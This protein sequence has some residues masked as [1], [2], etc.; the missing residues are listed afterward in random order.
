[1][2]GERLPVQDWMRA[3]ATRTV[4]TA[5]E[6]AGGPGA[7][8]FV[9]GC[10]R[11]AVIGRPIDDID[12]ATTL[13]P[14]AV[15]EALKAARVRFAPTG[16]DHGTLTAIVDGR[17]FEVT[18]LRRDVATDGRR[19]VVVFTTDWAEDARRRDFRLNALYLD[20]NG[21][22][23]DPLGEG[24]KDARAGRVVFVGDAEQRIR[25]DYL[26]IL[27]FFRFQAWYGREPADAAGLK[28]CGALKAGLAQL[29]AER[30]SRELLK[31]LAADDPCAALG[32]M[33]ASG[34]LQ[35]AL[36][37]AVGVDRAL[38]LVGIER[39]YFG[40]GDAELRL[41]ALWPADTAAVLAEADRLRLSKAQRDRLAAAVLADSTISPDLTAAQARGLI[42]RL[43]AQTFTDRLKLAWAGQA[44]GDP[45][46]WLALLALAR[47][48]TAP[49]FPVSG[50]DAAAAGLRPGP[51]MGRA[52]RSAED[53]WIAED[54]QPGRGAL[55][56]R[57][58][59][60]A[61]P[62]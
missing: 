49:P 19:A 22:L 51:A 53:W 18:S 23:Y 5:L 54:F 6:A 39:A 14:P 7:A 60:A 56:E 58:K 28:A 46:P 26:R 38:G 32:L 52:L 47:D 27:R 37:G 13:E 55:V 24:L 3:P 59:S 50:K 8:R 9:G 20:R 1:M 48:W 44:Q 40:S 17:P 25:E 16:L 41:A 2:P 21:E 61:E 11:N 31:L 45:Q 62:S 29:S 43:G 10:V 34:V 33:Q 57:L 42:Y 36:P 15:M 35:A 4:I 12:I 30:V